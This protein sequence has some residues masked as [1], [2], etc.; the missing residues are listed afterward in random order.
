MG[1][2]SYF[3]VMYLSFSG[4]DYTLSHHGVCYLEEACDVGTLHVV[5]VTLLAAVLYASLV[6]V[7]HDLVEH[8]VNLLCAPLEVL[9]VLSHLKT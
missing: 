1:R 4:L 8:V 3:D 7:E 5:D 6:D 2:S 9:S